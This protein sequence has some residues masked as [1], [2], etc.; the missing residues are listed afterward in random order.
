MS[1][2]LVAVPAK[3]MEAAGVRD[4]GLPS[5]SISNLS[6][7]RTA[8]ITFYLWL[9]FSSPCLGQGPKR[10]LPFGLVPHLSESAHGWSSKS[11]QNKSVQDCKV[12]ILK[13]VKSQMTHCRRLRWFCLRNRALLILWRKL[14]LQNDSMWL[15]KTWL[16]A[17]EQLLLVC[18]RVC[19]TG[20]LNCKHTQSARLL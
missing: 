12:N 7:L 4:Q 13:S 8:V 6:N 11:P 3:T 14:G 5:K 17:D 1:L 9:V 2:N 10:A 19:R 20:C 18:R 15:R 16:N